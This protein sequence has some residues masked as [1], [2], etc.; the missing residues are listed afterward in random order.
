MYLI[1]EKIAAERRNLTAGI[2][3][4]LGRQGSTS[5]YRWAMATNEE[6]TAI[7][8]GNGDGLTEQEVSC[9]ID[10]LPEESEWSVAKVETF[11]S[12]IDRLIA[13]ADAFGLGNFIQRFFFEHH[14]VIFEYRMNG[15][16]GLYELF[17]TATEEDY[18]ELYQTNEGDKTPRDYALELLG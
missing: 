12:K 14:E 8:V 16:S 15:G 13:A 11:K 4:G 18:P 7:N 1:L 5:R 3:I 10:E 9:C 2:A 17:N 6:L